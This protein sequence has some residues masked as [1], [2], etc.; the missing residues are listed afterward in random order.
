MTRLTLI[1]VAVL[2]TSAAFAQA[3]AATPAPAPPAAK[4]AV[5]PG[6]DHL[7]TPPADFTYSAGGRRDPF[8]TLA[9]GVGTVKEGDNPGMRPAG[10][11]GIAVDELSVKGI[12]F[13]NGAFVAMVSGAA[14]KTQTYTVKAG[15]KLYDGTVRAIDAR[16]VVIV[17]QVSDPL[18]V[19][20]QRE[21]RKL[22]RTQ[23]EGK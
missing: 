6:N 8:M 17:Q 14:G 9:R 4:A 3:P 21:V 7:P 12:V 2:L 15:S 20:K 11:A 5:A 22:L 23:E 13:T 16:S 1:V 10:A 18:S 19:E